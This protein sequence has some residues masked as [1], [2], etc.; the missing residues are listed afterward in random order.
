MK[1][2]NHFMETVKH[3]L[4][5]AVP[6]SVSTG[7]T[8]V[9]LE[10]AVSE[11]LP[12]ALVWYTTRDNSQQRAARIDIDKQVFLDDFGPVDRS[13]LTNEAELIV[14]FLSALDTRY[15]FAPALA[16]IATPLSER[17]ADPYAQPK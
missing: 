4:A 12:L 5:Q 8:F 11:S 1:S 6:P 2:N 15:T 3:D 16:G 9:S 13:L 14:N 17:I 10:Q 7:V